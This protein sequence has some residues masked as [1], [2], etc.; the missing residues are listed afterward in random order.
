VQ[1]PAFLDSRDRLLKRVSHVLD[2]SLLI[3][4]YLLLTLVKNVVSFQSI[5]KF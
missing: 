2:K 4:K 5:A 3:F 1:N